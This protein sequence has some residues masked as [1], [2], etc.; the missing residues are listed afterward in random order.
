MPSPTS[1]NIDTFIED[2][3]QSSPT[4]FCKLLQSVD[5][6]PAGTTGWFYTDPYPLDK[7][8]TRHIFKPY[9]PLAPKAWIDK[10]GVQQVAIVK[11]EDVG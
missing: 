11:K 7:T 9:N 10:Y 2:K 1:N 5:G 4:K 8:E 6:V 3:E